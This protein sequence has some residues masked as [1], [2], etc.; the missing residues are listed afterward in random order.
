MAAGSRHTGAR[1]VVVL[2]LLIIA[3]TS[4]LLPQ[5]IASH[6]GA[7][8][9]ANGFMTRTG[10]V[11][12]MGA[13]AIGVPTLISLFIGAAIRR[14]PGTIN[15]PNREYWLALAR[16]DDT[17]EFLVGY[18]ARLAAGVAVFAL[19]LHFLLIHANRLAP[20]RLE[21][22]YMLSLLGA[23]LVGV[24]AWVHGLMRRFRLP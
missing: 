11:F 24:A 15:I 13:I 12:F 2:A 7:D 5:R 9:L 8:G 16:R 23:V 20:P 4:Y 22:D 17:V 14:A 21:T 19:G 1:I 18:T 3:L 10:Y 6:F